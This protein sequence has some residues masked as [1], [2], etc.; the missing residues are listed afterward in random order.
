MRSKTR[1]YIKYIG[2]TCEDGFVKRYNLY[3]MIKEYKEHYEFI[4]EY[5]NKDM[6]H[7]KYFTTKVKQTDIK[8]KEFF[9]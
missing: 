8:R 6:M 4:N 2:N 7:K 1:K 5:N 3:T 9:K